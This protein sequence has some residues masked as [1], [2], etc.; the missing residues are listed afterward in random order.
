MPELAPE[1]QIHT[2]PPEVSPPGNKET[3]LTLEQRVAQLEAENKI[4]QERLAQQTAR[5]VAAEA[6]NNILQERLAQQIARAVAAE[7]DAATDVLTGLISR[8]VITTLLEKELAGIGR[9]GGRLAVVHLDLDHFKLVND[10]YGHEQGDNVLKDFAQAISSAM[11]SSDTLGRD[12]NRDKK[13]EGDQK[14]AEPTE[15]IGRLGGEEFI[16][17]L[18]LKDETTDQDIKNILMRYMEAVRQVN[19]S[20]INE[21]T[22][23]LTV[24]IG[25]A[26]VNSRLPLE[27]VLA[28]ADKATY[29]S[30]ETGR[31]RATILS[32]DEEQ[33]NIMATVIG[34]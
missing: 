10:T 18:P 34:S 22:I 1:T 23:P 17:L 26:I 27:V 2:K 4:L 21:E 24:S 25:C 32:I 31:N 8:R 20:N 12:N 5:A 9:H 6:E 19:R 30:K 13:D 7:K 14:I 29:V 28:A 11:R 16:I 3:N 15:K 33:T